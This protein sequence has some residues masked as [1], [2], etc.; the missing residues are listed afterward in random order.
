MFLVGQRV[1]CLHK[2]EIEIDACGSGHAASANN[3]GHEIRGA[4]YDTGI[5]RA[6]SSRIVNGSA[7]V[8]TGSVGMPLFIP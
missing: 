8:A 5:V 3:E 4:L 6:D 2:A 1:R 7:H